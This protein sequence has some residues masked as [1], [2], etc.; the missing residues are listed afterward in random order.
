M[1]EKDSISIEQCQII[2]YNQA[3]D[4]EIYIEF[5][6]RGKLSDKMLSILDKYTEGGFYDIELTP[7]DKAGNKL[8]DK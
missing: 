5:T 4:N 7:L 1:A 2:G 6:I 3:M 8:M